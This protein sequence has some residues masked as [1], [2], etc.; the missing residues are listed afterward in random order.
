MAEAC[1]V[2]LVEIDHDTALI[3]RYQI[4]S[5]FNCWF[6]FQNWWQ[7]IVKDEPDILEY[8]EV[9]KEN[10]EEN[11]VVWGREFLGVGVGIFIGIVGTMFYF[12]KV[13]KN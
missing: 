8:K 12:N 2:P 3:T 5:S 1:G 7:M 6:Q 10:V 11:R 13:R 9:K 4:A